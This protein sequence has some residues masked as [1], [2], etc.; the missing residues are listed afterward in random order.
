[1]A[2]GPTPCWLGPTTTPRPCRPAMTRWRRR[3]AFLS[4]RPRTARASASPAPT[5]RSSATAASSSDLTSCIV[6]SWWPPRPWSPWVGHCCMSCASAWRTP[7]PAGSLVT[8]LRLGMPWCRGRAAC[9]TNGSWQ[10]CPARPRFTTTMWHRVLVGVGPSGC[11]WSSRMRSAL[12][13]PR[14]WPES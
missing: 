4:C 2:T 13:Q 5:W 3:Q 1:M 7:I 10:T 8:W 6:L 14:S 12:R 9:C 11:T